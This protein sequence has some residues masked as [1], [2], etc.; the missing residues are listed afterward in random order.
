MYLPTAHGHLNY[1]QTRPQSAVEQH[2]TTVSNGTAGFPQLFACMLV[3]G[4]PPGLSISHDCGLLGAA[5]SQPGLFGLSLFPSS[6]SVDPHPTSTCIPR[7]GTHLRVT[8]LVFMSGT[9]GRRAPLPLIHTSHLTKDS[10]QDMDQTVSVP[11]TW[12]V[13]PSSYGNKSSSRL[14]RWMKKRLHL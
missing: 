13:S 6:P 1:D 9:R 14:W 5:S 10:K 3:V 4:V 7:P 12:S 11:P 2:L 8:S